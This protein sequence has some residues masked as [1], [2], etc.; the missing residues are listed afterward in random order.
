[1]ISDVRFHDEQPKNAVS[2]R[3]RFNGLTQ[4]ERRRATLARK[5]LNRHAIEKTLGSRD[6]LAMIWSLTARKSLTLSGE[7]SEWLK[8]HTWNESGDAH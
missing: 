4:F 5:L 7:M 8:E 2:D 3:T 1:M 6:A